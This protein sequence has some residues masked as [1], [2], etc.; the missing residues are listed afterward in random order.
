[1]ISPTV[2]LNLWLPLFFS[3]FNFVYAAPTPII[4]S[5]S[6]DRR[7]APVLVHPIHLQPIPVAR[8]SQLFTFSL[9]DTTYSLPNSKFT[10]VASDLPY[11]LEFSPSTA[12]FSGTPPANNKNALGRSTVTVTAS[13]EGATI[14]DE[15]EVVVEAAGTGV[16]VGDALSKQLNEN[17]K[18]LTSVFVLPV[19]ANGV[20]GLRVPNYVRP[21]SDAFLPL[22]R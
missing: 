3:L 13:G 15:F 14:R 1:M 19:G 4:R 7:A 22:L 5:S 17:N 16:K 18:A 8:V 10:L 12:T 9:I 21:S 2:S 20:G 6:L 11:W